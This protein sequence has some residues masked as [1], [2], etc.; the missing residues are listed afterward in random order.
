MTAKDE[1]ARDLKDSSPSEGLG[2]VSTGAGQETWLQ[3]RLDR[4]ARL[5]SLPRDWDSYGAEPPNRVAV[6]RS[7]HVLEILSAS[8]LPSPQITPSAEEGI[9]ISFRNGRFY[10]HIECFNSGEIVA[11]TSDGNGAHTLTEV[12]ADETE[13]IDK[14]KVIQA[15]KTIRAHLARDD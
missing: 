6:E 11:A 1:V 12:S 3:E 13:L 7:R 8:G 10:A 15:A 4:V 2:F 14:A 5:Q 9:C